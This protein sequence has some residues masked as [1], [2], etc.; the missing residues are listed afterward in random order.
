MSKL[1]NITGAAMVGAAALS[2]SA[3]VFVGDR[4]GWVSAA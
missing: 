4:V 1:R 2:V 3:A